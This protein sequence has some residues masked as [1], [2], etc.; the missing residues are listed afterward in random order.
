MEEKE[1]DKRGISAWYWTRLEKPLTDE[2]KNALKMALAV[3]KKLDGRQG[4]IRLLAYAM[5][6]YALYK[7]YGLMP[8]QRW[9]TTKQGRPYLP[10]YPEIDANLSHSGC[11]AVCAVGRPFL[12]TDIQ[13]TKAH[14]A[15]PL[16]QRVC[17]E[18]EL[19]WLWEKEQTR[20]ADAFTEIWALKESY[21]KWNGKG[22]GQSMRS[23]MAYECSPG[24][25]QTSIQGVRFC[26]CTPIPGYKAALCAGTE[27]LP[28]IQQVSQAQLLRFCAER[29]GNTG[30]IT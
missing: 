18:E 24:Q 15:R 22:L 20:R 21:L 10:E 19:R 16:A 4:D 9:Q 13:K 30:K 5:R 25:I 12:G 14:I 23:F 7:Q 8:K 29:A 11:M 6:S 1:R 27:P 17:T 28:K 2:Q 26:L 3:G